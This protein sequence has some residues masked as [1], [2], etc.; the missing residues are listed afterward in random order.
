MASWIIEQFPIHSIYVE[1]FGGAGSVL[2]QK[3]PVQTEVWND[4]DGDLVHLFRCLRDPDLSEQ[5]V[6]A[7]KLTPFARKEF[8][9]SYEVT[10]NPVERCRRF[11]VRSFFGYGSK[12]CISMSRNGFRC[13]RSG[14]NSPAVDW[15][16]YPA[17]LRNI[18]ERM[19]GVVI[20]SN[21]ALDVIR[22]FDRNDTLFY[23]DPPYVHST[24]N[25]DHGSYRHEMTDDDHREL[26][27]T[28]HAC[29]GMVIVSGY[30][31]H[32]YDQ[33]LYPDWH[34]LDRASYAD[35]SSPRTEVMWINHAAWKK[36]QCQS[37]LDFARS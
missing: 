13:L 25:L 28:L 14:S 20:E 36:K 7:C 23:V 4:L 12:S 11:I 6:T 21:P 15:S 17:A 19:Q 27:E 29:R 2:M 35:K 10:D 33:E 22:R 9:Q 34:R 18:I 32:L 3:I 24:R 30:P 31:C 26:S 1:P 37:V 5:L 8:E 16:S